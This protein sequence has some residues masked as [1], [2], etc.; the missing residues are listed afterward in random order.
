MTADK[1]HQER[2]NSI[3]F[4]FKLLFYEKMLLWTWAI[5]GTFNVLWNIIN[6][7]S[8]FPTA[9]S[10]GFFLLILREYFWTHMCRL[11]CYFMTQTG[12]FRANLSPKS[13]HSW[14]FRVDVFHLIFHIVMAGNSVSH[15][16]VMITETFYVGP[17]YSGLFKTQ[18]WPKKVLVYF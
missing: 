14:Y 10:F 8:Y 1:T 16:K 6:R 18:F 7:I 13:D 4:L 17:L 12:L 2:W 11:R 3:F 9:S 5:L 15:L